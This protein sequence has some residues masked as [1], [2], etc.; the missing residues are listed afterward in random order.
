M[1]NELLIPKYEVETK[2]DNEMVFKMAPLERGYGQM[3]GYLFR[4]ILLS[5]MLGTSIVKV[6]IDGVSHEYT[7]ITGVVQDVQ[8]L[9]LNLKGVV[10]KPS[11]GDVTN[12]CIDVKGPMTVTAADIQIDNDAEIIN[13]D[14]VICEISGK[15]SL[16]INMIAVM[17]RGYETASSLSNNEV[18]GNEVNALYLDASFSPIDSVVYHVDNARVGNRTD[19][20]KLTLIVKTNGTITPDQAVRRVATIMQHQ[21]SNFASI[22]ERKN[23]DSGSYLDNIDPV[24][25]RLVDELELTV[26]AA[27]CL[28][29]ENIRYIGELVQCNEYD[30]LRTPNLGRKSMNEIKAVLAELGLTLGM[31]IPEWVSPLEHIKRKNEGG[32]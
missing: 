8:T 31:H 3:F 1:Y 18:F 7:T 32:E 12:L 22:H 17:G 16:K 9:L 23:E 4:R 10:I 19:L 26:R 25:S 11:N 5:S 6:A 2:S 29:S 24:Y 14:H 28:K 30:L 15:E 21:L 13:K 20:D 27:N